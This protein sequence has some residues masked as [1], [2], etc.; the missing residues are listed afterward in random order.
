[1]DFI[2]AARLPLSSAFPPTGP[3]LI[4]FVTW[5]FCMQN[6]GYATCKKYLSAVRSG[7]VDVGASIAGFSS[8]RLER[9]MRGI[10]RRDRG[11][12]RQPRLPITVWLLRRIFLRMASC[13]TLIWSMSRAA[14][15]IGV[16]GLL[17]AGSFVRKSPEANIL[18]RADVTWEDVKA[19]IHL[20][21]S[22]TDIYRRGVDVPIFRTGGITCPYANLKT[23]WDAAPD[24]AP[25]AAL[26]QDTKGAPYTYATLM[27]TIRVQMDAIGFAS[28]SYGT[29]S[30]RIGGAT[31]LALLGV[32]A[33][34][35]RTM[36]RWRSLAYQLYTRVDHATMARTAGS[37]AAAVSSGG[38]DRP[39]GKLSLD[40]AAGLSLDNI[41]E[42]GVNFRR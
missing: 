9:V 5:L 33:H 18:M 37:M 1:M 32:P 13:S 11:S 30:L 12:R 24:Q 36:G 28:S 17:R 25:Q 4:G 20:R 19:T 10:R 41:H 35:I 38:A 2:E 39:F 7:C 6:V 31:S 3:M 26:L 40:K 27:R 8:P 15:A 23:A 42:I 29:H 34:I 21:Q 14:M 22:K 16:Y